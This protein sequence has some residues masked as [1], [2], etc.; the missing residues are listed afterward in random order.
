MYRRYLTYQVSRAGSEVI[1]QLLFLC[2]KDLT[3]PIWDDGGPNGI[4]STNHMYFVIISHEALEPWER[5]LLQ[6]LKL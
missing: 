5:R 2:P 4:G 3:K 1:E 6:P